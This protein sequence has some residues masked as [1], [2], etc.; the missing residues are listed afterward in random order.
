M[1]PDRRLPDGEGQAVL[2]PHRRWQRVRQAHVSQEI[3]QITRRKLP[4]R[5]RAR[6]LG[7]DQRRATDAFQRKAPLLAR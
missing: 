1:G 4:H 6:E 2:D 3:E 5:S 7:A